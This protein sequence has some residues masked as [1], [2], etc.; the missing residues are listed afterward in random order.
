M[1]AT[2][3][4]VLA[5]VVGSDVAIVERHAN[6]FA[7]TC[8]SEIVTCRS[9]DGRELRLLFKHAAG[10]HHLAF[11]HRGGTAYEALVYRE[12]VSQCGLSAPRFWNDLSSDTTLVIEFLTDAVCAEAAM[13]T[14]DAMATAARWAGRFHRI[15][16]GS[17][18][19][20]NRYD[21]EYYCVWPRRTAE[22]A[23]AW[24]QRL[25]WLGALCSKAETFMAVLV[26]QPSSVIHG[27]FT[28]HN[29]LIRGGVA[30]PIDWESGAIAF[31]EIDLA[32][33]TDK[34]P[35]DIVTGCEQE[36]QRARWPGSGDGGDFRYR[37]DLAR[38]YWNFRW[39]GDR[40]EWTS[41][42]KVGPR[43]EEVRR[44]AERLGLL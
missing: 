32:C 16:T 11:G 5:S 19:P 39:L 1:T 23:G 34:W 18:A 44:I 10:P 3:E 24:H 27:E 4:S 13:P 41:S 9:Q 6:A 43:F 21:R 22:L 38:L 28:P 37:L 33:L 8:P 31:G 42:E 17:A 14:A 20:L 12:V 30:Y 40:P 15:T 26:D 36:Y 7:S 25:P 2:I 35:S 29:V